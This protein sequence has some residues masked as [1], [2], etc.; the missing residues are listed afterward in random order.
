MHN[1]WP[2]RIR[3][4]SEFVDAVVRAAADTPDLA[5]PPALAEEFDEFLG[6][7]PVSD[8]SVFNLC[9]RFS[10]TRLLYGIY[11]VYRRQSIRRMGSCVRTSTSRLPRKLS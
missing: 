1:R 9:E 2:Y 6:E 4:S 10:S 3:R 8:W 11:R 7:K 5:D